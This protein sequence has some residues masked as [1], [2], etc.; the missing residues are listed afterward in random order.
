MLRGAELTILQLIEA[1]RKKNYNVQFD[2]LTHFEQVKERIE[3]AD[4]VVYN[5]SSRCRF[6]KEM[7]PFLIE[8]KKLYIK[9]EYDY[10]FCIRR[11]ILCT[12]DRGIR[13]C[14]DAAKFHLYRDLFAHAQLC[15]FQSPAHLKAHESFYGKAVKNNFIMPPT[16]QVDELQP[17]EHKTDDIIPFFG[18]LNYYK[19]GN[20][21]IDYA[22]ENPD[23][24]FIVY[25][26]NRLKREIPPNV[27]FHSPVPNHE[28]LKIMGTTKTMI[29]QPVWPEPSGRM[30]AEAFLSGVNILG[31]ENI[32]TFSFDFY[33]NHPEQ[34]KKEMV[35][36]IED[37][38]QKIDE[39][40]NRKEIIPEESL[41]KV[42]VYKS[43]G[44]LG[45]IFFC[46]PALNLLSEVSTELSFAVAPRLVL[47][48]SRHI[49][50]FKIVNENEARE[51]EALYDHVFELGNYPA[52]RGYD[53][54]YALKY[55]THKKV[56][57][58]AISHY[59]DTVS[60]LHKDIQPKN[61][62]RYPYFEKSTA[63]EP[64]YTVHPGA[65]FL[66]KIWPTEKYALLIEMIHHYFPELKC[67]IILGPGD[68]DPR[69][70]M[71]GDLSYMIPVTGGMT[72]VGE[73]MEGA[74]F[75]IGND[76]GITH[77]AGAFNVP[78]LAIYGP[79][80]PGSWGSFAEKNEIVWGKK[81]ACNIKCNYDVI[82]NCEHKICLN[83]VTHKRM[84]GH[85]LILLRKLENLNLSNQ[86]IFNTAAHYN[87][88][89]NEFILKHDEKEF[90]IEFQSKNDADLFE[91]LLGEAFDSDKTLP[92]PVEQLLSVMLEQDMFFILPQ[93]SNSIK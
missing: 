22:L 50:N 63:S 88:E 40:L 34:A 59:I 17:N 54:P 11:N 80:G 93:F 86:M 6:E 44:G 45:D 36:T 13:S 41:G 92:E 8:S 64:Y 10:N 28:V 33:P 29:I 31:N 32:G 60:M 48:F 83:S 81:G 25:G 75:H 76:A 46:L 43:Y 4:I 67:R 77:V 2:Q 65:G 68:P 9:T 47:F 53:L 26:E 90:L 55:P 52:F 61:Y 82:L 56:K 12:V 79:T 14:C 66:L 38:W 20:A 71:S 18:E 42:L 21:Y 1:S 35:Q 30:A 37:F 16:V 7:I 74:I 78:T 70:F 5:S 85:L 19:G 73:A 87:R 58:H 84:F 62:K 57:Q 91:S 72:D 23:K 69:E 49:S 24:T 27:Q 39:I 89:A 3:S 15:V 51:N